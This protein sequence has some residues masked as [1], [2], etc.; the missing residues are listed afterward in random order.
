MRR[1]LGMGLAATL[2]VLAGVFVAPVAA[3]ASTGGTIHSGG[4]NVNVRN[5]PGTNYNI[6]GSLAQGAGVSVYCVA[7]GTAVSG[8][9]GTTTLWDEIGGGKW[10]TDAFVDTGTN[11]PIAQPCN[12]FGPGFGSVVVNPLDGCGVFVGSGGNSNAGVSVTGPDWGVY[13]NSGCDDSYFWT[14]GNGPNPSNVDYV[15]WGYY[16]GAFATCSVSVHIPH[17]HDT[18]TAVPFTYLAHYDL[19]TNKS[20]PI[21]L[22]DTIVNQHVNAGQTVSLGTWQADGSGYLRVRMDDSSSNGGNGGRVAV[23][24]DWVEFACTTSY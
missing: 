5:G 17:V 18:T 23:A 10:V 4:G 22:G 3:Y 16:P 11:D 2:A 13:G 19:Y 21:L 6:V 12:G 7:N 20:S 9:F 8:P 14:Y 1:R 15:T 24:A